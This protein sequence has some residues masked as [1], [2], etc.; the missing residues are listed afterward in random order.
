MA[1]AS[2]AADVAEA[3]FFRGAVGVHHGAQADH[4][5]VAG[6][7]DALGGVERGEDGEGVG[8]GV[9]EVGLDGMVVDVDESGVH[10][11]FHFLW[12]TRHIRFE[13]IKRATAT[14]YNSLLDYGGWGVRL[15]P[16]GWAFNTG[17]SEGVLIETVKGKRIMIGSHRAMELKEAIARASAART[18]R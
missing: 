1:A 11:S 17:G 3:G 2:V 13:D 6:E 9:T 18:S 10:A 7:G 4:P 14:R 8:A 12:P 5:G 16:K 15:T